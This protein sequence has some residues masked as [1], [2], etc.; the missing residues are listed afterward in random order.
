MYQRYKTEKDYIIK[1]P[2]S[3]TLEDIYHKKIKR[4]VVN[5]L[6]ADK[7]IRPT[8][9]Y[10][11]LVN[12]QEEYMF[13]GVG[14]EFEIPIPLVSDK[15]LKTRG[16]VVVQVT[17]D[18]HPIFKIDTL[19]TP[20][21]LHVERKVS[22]YQYFYGDTFDLD[23]FGQVIS[24]EYEN[25]CKVKVL[26][27]K[28]LPYYDEDDDKESRGDIYVFFDVILPTNFREIKEDDQLRIAV[29]KYMSEV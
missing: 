10:I 24:I 6:N 18:E 14:D 9:I 19:L 23:V 7:T 29:Q 21:D 26:K 12:Y 16:D 17:I 2:V 27:E 13:K 20:Y 25:G 4:I 3:V 22:L 8:P 1:I 28:G 15:K 11:S 5:T